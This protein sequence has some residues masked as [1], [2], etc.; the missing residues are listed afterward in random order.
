MLKKVN[1]LRITAIGLTIT[2]LTSMFSV[3]SPVLAADE[4]IYINFNKDPGVLNPGQKQRIEVNV[5]NR[6]NSKTLMV[7]LEFD[8]GIKVS[9][10]N[11]WREEGFIYSTSVGERKM[12]LRFKG[13]HYPFDKKKLLAFD[14][15]AD[16][17]IKQDTLVNCNVQIV[18]DLNG[19][20]FTEYPPYTEQ[21]LVTVPEIEENK[22]LR[23]STL[24]NKTSFFVGE[25]FQAF[26][27][28]LTYSEDGKE[29]TVSMMDS[30][31]KTEIP[32]MST[33]GEK[34]VKMTYKGITTSYKI[35]VINPEK[36]ELKSAPSP[37]T[38]SG[39]KT[40]NYWLG[41]E[42]N[43]CD[44]GYLT[45]TDQTNTKTDIKITK[46]MISGY[47]MNVTGK[48]TLTITYDGMTVN[49]DIEVKENVI[50]GISI[51]NA[52]SK[53]VYLLNEPLDLKDATIAVHKLSGD[54]TLIPLSLEM[55][56]GYDPSKEGIQE[57]KVSYQGFETSFKVT[58]ISGEIESLS[59]K[60]APTPAFNKEAR[61]TF[62]QDQDF[63]IMNDGI[64]E[65]KYKG[66]DEVKEISITKEMCSNYD[67]SKVGETN[68]TVSYGGATTVYKASIEEK[69]ITDLI[70]EKAPDKLTYI[71]GKDN[72]LDLS[73]INLVAVYNNGKSNS[74]EVS[75]DM[76]SGY[77]L[78]VLGKQ[79]VTL[80]YG[81]RTFNFDIEV[82]TGNPVAISIKKTPVPIEF[83]EGSE[84]ACE[85]GI[86]TVSYEGGL[87]EEV[88]I[89]ADMCSGFDSS[90]IGQKVITVSYRGFE[91]IY[92]IT[93]VPKTPES[94]SIKQLPS[95]TEYIKGEELDVTN[96]LFTAHYDNG[97][98]IDYPIEK[99]MCSGFDPEK[100]GKQTIT[101][102]FNGR[103]TE[104]E[105]NVVDRSLT[106]I[107]LIHLPQQQ[108]IIGSKFTIEG[109]FVTLVY[110][111]GTTEDISMDEKEVEVSKPNLNKLGKQTVDVKYKEYTA[112]YEI[113]VVTSERVDALDEKLKVLPKKDEMDRMAYFADDYTYAK[114]L[115][116]E[117]NQLTDGE[118]T[119][120]KEIERAYHA[121]QMFE[122]QTLSFTLKADDKELV[123]EG[124]PETLPLNTEI[125][126]ETMNGTSEVEIDGTKYKVINSYKVSFTAKNRDGGETQ[127]Y[128]QN[129]L[130]VAIPYNS[131]DIKGKVVKA[132]TADK[133]GHKELVKCAYMSGY[134]V[135]ETKNL[136]ELYILVD[137]NK[138]DQDGNGV[139]DEN[140]NNGEQG[141]NNTPVDSK[142]PDA[143]QSQESGPATGINGT[144]NTFITVLISITLIGA[145]LGGVFFIKK[146]GKGSKRT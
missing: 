48:Q 67:L 103:T 17:N 92:G 38:S 24:P 145:A 21:F 88:P 123:F 45:Y 11:V 69:Q 25:P 146:R 76:C 95:K 107:K 93:I 60:K 63:E 122:G 131:E 3:F 4:N 97:E 57:I 22:G 13:D 126:G 70:L 66:I 133:N 77:D 110:N 43:I 14:I 40:S 135:F 138:E 12:V 58:V 82:L 121:I 27:G 1:A 106:G 26:G 124:I 53:L 90:V 91:T 28:T 71:Q 20:T 37:A 35:V 5:D 18:A 86:L 125:H 54:Y 142:L 140:E 50:S 44:D 94:L 115:L 72:V 36:L 15:I 128:P 2:F 129:S 19:E 127:Y 105:V 81:D 101:I 6:V 144:Q 30:N 108:F 118:K 80:M 84:F 64:L 102:T 112:S 31:V 99:Y 114:N 61:Q 56:S 111:N 34:E 41:Q 73:G 116:E 10:E 98:N 120:V 55:V 141:G 139:V 78:T 16:S 134:V 68:V 59:I 75:Q 85:E 62:I 143:I 113:E 23:V 51:T 32:D 29:E 87:T 89:T 96:G 49:Y 74:L 9:T 136:D 47:D 104:F 100:L 137:E 46:E 119:Y 117:F 109:G 130:K 52:P 79:T 39:E 42:F 7:V 33:P 65:C 132:Y 8:E 83:V